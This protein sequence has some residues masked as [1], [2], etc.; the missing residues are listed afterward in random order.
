MPNPTPRVKICSA[1]TD[2]LKPPAD[3][4]WML[5]APSTDDWNDFDYELMVEVYLATHEEIVHLSSARLL[6]KAA[7]KTS[8][9][10]RSLSMATPFA[11]DDGLAGQPFLFGL[12]GSDKYRKLVERVG[13]NNAK[14]MLM[15]VH[16][17]G[18]L[19]A[20]DPSSRSLDEF[21]DSDGYSKGL[22]R[23]DGAFN[24][25]IELEELLSFPDQNIED[26]E[27]VVIRCDVPMPYGPTLELS[28]DY[29]T[30]PFGM[31]RINVLI[32]ENGVGKTEVL[33]FLARPAEEIK[34]IAAVYLDNQDAAGFE[35]EDD[36]EAETEDHNDVESLVNAQRHTLQWFRRVDFMP[37]AVDVLYRATKPEAGETISLATDPW[38]VTTT[39]AW[40]VLRRAYDPAADSKR[41][42]DILGRAM[43]GYVDL[44]RL[45]LPVTVR[46]APK[47]KWINTDSGAYA[48]VFKNRHGE[49]RM[50]E[51]FA[52][53]DASRGPIFVDD[54]DS[55]MRLSSGQRIFFQYGLALIRRVSRRSLFL[56]DEPELALHPQMIAALMRLTDSILQAKRAFAVVA[57]HSLHLIRE[58]QRDAVHVL[59]RDKAGIPRDLGP[60]MQTFGAD[61]SELSSVVFPD[62]S[63]EELFE[64]KVDQTAVAMLHEE[65]I[66]PTQPPVPRV[67]AHAGPAGKRAT[68]PNTP[69]QRVRSRLGGYLGSVGANYLR[70]KLNNV[71]KE[72]A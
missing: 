41:D 42:W 65:R 60:Y 50:L 7:K 54:N 34:D 62:E 67:P 49:E 22:L 29:A 44:N 51:L 56:L 31:T 1:Y 6:L 52:S 28:L 32:G 59:I 36:D 27:R 5:I 37:S 43:S 53:I 26:P 24:A 47:F 19:L 64:V 18:A 11:I 46:K 15:E 70:D 71:G 2:S 66:T 3:E 23:F 17:W 30:T 16:D 35:T 38:S 14:A 21:I 9:Y 68:V 39:D 8:P 4:L 58:V 57:T 55:V 61:L 10:L 25:G 45:C 48:N 40:A 20:F 13:R 33:R 69:E 72:D 63:I 12:S